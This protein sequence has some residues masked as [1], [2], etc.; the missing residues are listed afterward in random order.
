MQRLSARPRRGGPHRPDG[1]RRRPAAGGRDRGRRPR[2]R[3]R[4]SRPAA[5]THLCH[6]TVER[7]FTLV[8][9]RARRRRRRDRRDVHAL[10]RCWTRTTSR[11][12]GGRAKINPP[13]RPRAQ[14]EALW[15]LL[16]AGRV[17]QVTSDHVGWAREL[18]DTSDDLGGPLGRARARDDAAA[19]LQRGRRAP[20][21]PARPP[22]GG[23]LRGPGPPLR[24]LAAQ[25]RDRAGRRCRPRVLDPAER[26]RIDEAALPSPPAGART[27]GAT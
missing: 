16:A 7:G 23:A 12:L 4:R 17:D 26:W 21:A 15:R 27:T 24:P 22:A 18:K 2:A 14:L 8:A 20:R 10:P 6:V 3:A 1:A 9:A 25:G 11:R 13:L 5:P 19:A